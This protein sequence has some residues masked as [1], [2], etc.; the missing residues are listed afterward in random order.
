M[1]STIFITIF[2]VTPLV[3]GNARV[4][5]TRLGSLEQR[6]TH[7]LHSNTLYKRTCTFIYILIDL[8]G[9]LLVGN[10]AIQSPLLIGKSPIPAA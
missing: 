7:T 3:Y 5:F 8:S 2:F 4:V 6:E 10:E 9:I 1:I